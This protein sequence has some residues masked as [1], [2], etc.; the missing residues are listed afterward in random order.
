MR[1]SCARTSRSLTSPP[2][3]ECWSRTKAIDACLLIR[4]HSGVRFG[5]NS[6]VGYSEVAHTQRLP[7]QRPAFRQILRFIELDLGVTQGE[8]NFADGRATSDL[9]GLF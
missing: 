7:E 1:S 4:D 3:V 8:L 6:L 5:L 9:T 2:S